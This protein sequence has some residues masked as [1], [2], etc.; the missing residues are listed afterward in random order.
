MMRKP[1]LYH[2]IPRNSHREVIGLIGVHPGAGVTYTGLLLAFYLGEEL[3]RKT[4]YLECN[5][6]HDF[7]R[8]QQAY[9]WNREDDFSFHFGNNSFHKD[10]TA[11]KI[12]F[13]LGEDYEYILL[14]FGYALDTSIGEFNRCSRK[15]VIGGWAD[16]N[17]SKLSGFIRAAQ[18]IRGY[19]AWTYLLPYAGERAIRS[20][21]QEFD[22]RFYSIPMETDPLKPSKETKRL[23]RRLLE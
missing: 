17:L 5:G 22:G 11:D 6:H 19:D 4:A 20:I 8:L 1:M 2:N 13:L 3:G 12:P 10:V 18:S 14:D 21:Q 9:R 15:L 23:F 7:S 16:W